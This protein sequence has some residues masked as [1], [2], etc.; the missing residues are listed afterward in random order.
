MF[1]HLLSAL[2]LTPAI[3]TCFQVVLHQAALLNKA[4]LT[5]A[6][7]CIASVA[8][9]WWGAGTH[10]TEH[11]RGV[12]LSLRLFLLRALCRRGSLVKAS[13]AGSPSAADSCSGSHDRNG[14]W[15]NGIV[16]SFRLS[17]AF[18]S[19]V[20]VLKARN[21]NHV[22]TTAISYSASSSHGYR[23]SLLGGCFLLYHRQSVLKI[24]L[25]GVARRRRWQ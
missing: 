18:L 6:A 8:R 15:R 12:T 3:G 24:I 20:D 23:S 5:G 22:P 16:R 2:L 10:Y 19:C 4:G 9:G 1:D 21:P 13:S 25:R 11:H 14:L 17:Q 7:V